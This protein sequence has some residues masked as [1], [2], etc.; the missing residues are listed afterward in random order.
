MM[1][2]AEIGPAAV[3]PAAP[4]RRV[5]LA[6]LGMTM[7]AAP[8]AAQGAP[9]IQRAAAE[10]IRTLDLQLE[11]PRDPE[12]QPWRIS[13]PPEVMW[14]I[15]ACGGAV[16]LYLLVTNFT[17]DLVPIWRWR[18]AP[19]DAVAD[20]AG[21]GAPPVAAAVIA[22]DELA[23][24]G[25][26]VEAMHM[27]LLQ[28]LAEIRQRLG[29]HFADSLT[30]WEILRSTRLSAAG[31]ASLREIITRVQ[32]THF[33]EHPAGASEYATCRDRYNELSRILRSGAAH[34]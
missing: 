16:L 22:A 2:R 21:A 5:A 26:F 24:E 7:L 29:E 9:D 19:E 10:A 23:R 6:V 13:L 34:E 27:L 25:R 20:S 8:L 15:L 31:R 12:E 18:R 32:W 11:L 28:S 4:G 17:M 30:S 33:G 1:G 14:G 3:R